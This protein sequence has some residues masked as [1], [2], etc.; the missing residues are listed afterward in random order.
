MFLFWLM[1]EMTT[2]IADPP[3]NQQHTNKYFVNA[4]VASS[5]FSGCLKWQ[6]ELQIPPQNQQH[7]NKY[8]VKT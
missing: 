4:R 1:F 8:F 7:A 5:E 2:R 6:Q 3:P